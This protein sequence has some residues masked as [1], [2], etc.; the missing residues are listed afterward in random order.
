MYLSKGYKGYYYLY[1]K[2]NSGT[3]S[4]ISTRSKIKP[5]ALK[6]I[7]E[8]KQKLKDKSKEKENCKSLFVSELRDEVLKYVSLN[9]QVSTLQIYKRVFND[10]V[11]ILGN[12]PI[13]LIN[14]IDL[15]HYKEIRL[16]EVKQWTVNIDLRT[17]KAIF[18]IA[19]KFEYISI[20][21]MRYVKLLSIPDKE[22]LSFTNEQIKF[23]TSNIEHPGM[24]NIVLFALNTGCRLNEAVNIQWKDVNLSDMVLTIRNKENFKTK[25]GKIRQIPINESLYNLLT[26]MIKSENNILKFFNP[27]RYI[28]TNQNGYKF[29]K[30][31]VTKMF[32]G[33]LRKLNIPEKYHF[34]C[35]RHT[36]ITS[37]IKEGVNINYVKEIAGHSDIKTTMNYIHIQTED[38]RNAVNKI[39]FL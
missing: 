20:N 4:K 9:M 21:P 17:I 39:N 32:K 5:D 6:F 37:L 3:Y 1:Y 7:S 36:F 33:T 14:T 31:Y 30:N 8:F 18:N 23:I 15:E 38:L 27:E 12:K 25:T 29:N 2:N 34:H 13:K 11:R 26:R 28:F 24:R 35:L 19:L 22:N 16:N 10:I